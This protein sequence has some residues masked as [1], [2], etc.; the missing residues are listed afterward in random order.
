MVPAGCPGGEL[1]SL[2]V[3]SVLSPGSLVR[4]PESLLRLN[5]EKSPFPSRKKLLWRVYKALPPTSAGLRAYL[6]T[7]LCFSFFSSLFSILLTEITLWRCI[8]KFDHAILILCQGKLC[9]TVIFFPTCDW[10]LDISKYL[11]IQNIAYMAMTYSPA[12]TWRHLHRLWT[13]CTDVF[14]HRSQHLKS[15]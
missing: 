8:C 14:S 6:V 11:E 1:P 7:W 15:W 5:G 3:K 2:E 13:W 4:K 9:S 10:F 12:P